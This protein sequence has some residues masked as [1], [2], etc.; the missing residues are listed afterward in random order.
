MLVDLQACRHA[1]EP[2]ISRVATKQ[3]PAERSS[4]V[5]LGA[6]AAV[7][8]LA[9][10]LGWW[11]GRSGESTT[12]PPQYSS[13]QMTHD[14]GITVNPALSPD[15]RL[16]A[17]AS[18][19]HSPGDLNIWVQQVAGGDAALLTKHEADDRRPSF[20]PDGSQI[21]FESDRDGG[22]I[23]VVSTL[24]G[25]ARRVA[26]VERGL[27][28]A[29]IIPRFSPDGESISFSGQESDAA[30]RF[31]NRIHL[32]PFSGGS[33]QQVEVDLAIAHNP[34]WSPDGHYLLFAG[35]AEPA[36]FGVRSRGD[37]WVVPV[38]GGEA[39]PLG[40]RDLFEENSIQPTRPRPEWIQPRQWMADGNYILFNA[41]SEGGA[42][43]LWR[44]QISA[45]GRRLLGEPQRLTSGTGEES[46]SAAQ[47]GRI[48]FVN[49]IQ[50]WDIWKL[51]IDANAVEVLGEPERVV[52]GLSRDRYP[53]IPA[54]ARR[55]I[56][57]SN[58]AGNPDIWLHDPATGPDKQITVGPSIEIRGEISPDGS[59][60]VFRR[61]D[62]NEIGLYLK[63][64][65]TETETRVV[66]G[67]FA[68]FMDW[69]PDGKS[70]LYYTPSPNLV[71]SCTSSN[72]YS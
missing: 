9:L 27:R 67:P 4:P 49:A 11:F 37:W 1:L 53:S 44:V 12:Q 5:V 21:V 45:D 17:Y 69:T 38:E 8:L 24:G 28:R 13:R 59:R 66:E 33:A 29:L 52:S 2:K 3:A 60:V 58:R 10:G 22:G 70:I 68:N 55:L 25:S 72:S 46:P 23:Y 50:D 51:P 42:S 35:T 30:N 57:T 7:V 48:A 64:L 71:L 34:V 14:A 26:G 31:Y 54:D 41:G 56:Y 36:G 6:M 39:V 19:R 18:D 47:D 61:I 65:A 16:L 20:S 32:V 15:G 40:A 63:D 43:N 62:N